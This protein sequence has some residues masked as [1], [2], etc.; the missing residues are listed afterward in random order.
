MDGEIDRDRERETERHNENKDGQYYA[1][2]CNSLS[3]SGNIRSWTISHLGT[4]LAESG[5]RT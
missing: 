5:E 4:K 2:V 3:A 1:P